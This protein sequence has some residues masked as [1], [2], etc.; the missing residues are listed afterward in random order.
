MN[1][2]VLRG[3]NGNLAKIYMNATLR[4]VAKKTKVSNNVNPKWD[5]LILF[6][7]A[8]PFDGSLVL[9]VKVQPNADGE[10][11]VIIGRCT[12][13]MEN[14]QKRDND[15]PVFSVW[16]N[17]VGPKGMVGKLHMRIFLNGGYLIFDESIPYNSDFRPISNLGI[18]SIGVLHLGILK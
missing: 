4:D 18:P 8:E 14:V 9:I 16:Y 11:S 12:V 15:A 13:L 2:I 10:R 1:E 7:V 6:F 17:L 5:E 3:N